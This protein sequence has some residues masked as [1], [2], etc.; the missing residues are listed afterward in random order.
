MTYE[1]KT[2]PKILES[3]LYGA[4]GDRD[5]QA[6]LQRIRQHPR[7]DEITHLVETSERSRCRRIKANVPIVTANAPG[8][9][10]GWYGFATMDEMNMFGLD[11]DAVFGSSIGA[12]I[13]LVQASMTP[14]SEIHKAHQEY[15][16]SVIFQ[17]SF[18]RWGIFSSDKS[19]MLLRKNFGP[20]RDVREWPVPIFPIATNRR[21]LKA[22]VFMSGQTYK[23]IKAST[24]L[25]PLYPPVQIDGEEYIDGGFSVPSPVKQARQLAGE[26]GFVVAID[27]YSSKVENSHDLDG[28]LPIWKEIILRLTPNTLEASKKNPYLLM[29]SLL[30]PH[31]SLASEMMNAFMASQQNS[32]DSA[33]EK[34]PPDLHICWSDILNGET[35][36]PLTLDSFQ[37]KDQWIDRGR[38][39]FERYSM[40]DLIDF[41]Y[42]VDN[43]VD[44]VLDN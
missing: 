44:A 7:I 16:T 40:D 25:S 43:R 28:R 9:L 18:T 27:T 6:Y 19:I 26:K 29:R 38:E 41:R 35:A 10:R 3:R 21:T 34:T 15:D 17:K 5:R 13:G 22:R 36:I 33:L 14:I 39:G 12:Y 24:A 8:L 11:P 2:N 42:K 37:R 32:I 4:E 30:L 20:D 1:L 31:K 23:A